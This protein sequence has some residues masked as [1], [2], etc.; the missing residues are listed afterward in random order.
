MDHDIKDPQPCQTLTRPG[1]RRR[2]LQAWVKRH[3]DCILGLRHK[4][5]LRC[6]PLSPWPGIPS[7]A[8]RLLFLHCCWAS[9]HSTVH[10]DVGIA[11]YDHCWPWSHEKKPE[12]N[13][14]DPLRSSKTSLLAVANPPIKELV[15]TW[16]HPLKA[17]H[18][19][20]GSYPFWPLLQVKSI[21]SMTHP[22]HEQ[23]LKP[24]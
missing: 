2:C 11:K 12:M 10:F 16:L 23:T 1:S 18:A 5:Y 6:K 8:K 3:N 22:H 9:S 17:A 14:S 15:L 20:T 24:S 21:V 7:A 4:L 19:S 13:S